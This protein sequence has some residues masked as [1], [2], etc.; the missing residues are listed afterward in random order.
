M[1]RD[2]GGTQAPADL[3]GPTSPLCYAKPSGKV[4]THNVVTGA[5]EEGC[6]EEAC[7]QGGERDQEE[8]VRQDPSLHNM[9]EGH[10]G[11]PS[12]HLIL[13]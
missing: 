3:L 8:V 12:N 6:R 5:W 10:L 4:R 13:Y 11:S 1:S 2:P 7:V 9:Q